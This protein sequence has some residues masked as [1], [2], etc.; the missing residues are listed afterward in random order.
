M[1][2]FSVFLGYGTV[3]NPKIRKKSGQFFEREFFVVIFYSVAPRTV[4][5]LPE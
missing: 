1:R 4:V 2:D 5:H 3:R